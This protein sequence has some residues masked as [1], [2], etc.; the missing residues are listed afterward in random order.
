MDELLR[1]NDLVLISYVE[2]LLAD[3]QIDAVVLDQH[4]SILEGSIGAIQRRIMV[5]SE[6]LAAARTVL[7]DMGID[8]DKR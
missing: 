1:T 7:D 5:L 3:Q 4:T 6:D 8:Y 2:A